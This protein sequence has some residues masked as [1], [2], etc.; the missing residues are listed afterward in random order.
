MVSSE[1]SPGNYVQSETLPRR[2]KKK[3]PPVDPTEE[4][5]MCVIT[6]PTV[7]KGSGPILN[8]ARSPTANTLQEK[9]NL[10]ALQRGNV[11]TSQ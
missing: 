10:S 7:Q 2:K 1:S 3:K 8:A 4:G 11:A 9:H 6:L 5:N